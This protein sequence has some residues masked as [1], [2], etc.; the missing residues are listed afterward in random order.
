MTGA[1]HR[2]PSRSSNAS[3]GLFIGMGTLLSVSIS[4]N[5]VFYVFLT[6]DLVP[7]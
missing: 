2:F 7:N 3:I 5:A 6:W 4:L 1:K